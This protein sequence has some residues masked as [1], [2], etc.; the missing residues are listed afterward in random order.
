MSPQH[1]LRSFASYLA[2]HLTVGRQPGSSSKQDPSWGNEPLW[3]T[4]LTSHDP[5]FLRSDL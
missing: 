4:A 3:C 1:H 2:A 5:L